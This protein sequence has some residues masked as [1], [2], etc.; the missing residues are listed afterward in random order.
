M[1]KIV[2]FITI[3][4]IFLSFQT[5]KPAANAA[6]PPLIWIIMENA[7]DDIVVTMDSEY[8]Q[9][10]AQIIRV[11]NESY[12][13]FFLHEFY[14]K[15]FEF[16]DYR[17]IQVSLTFSFNQE[18]FS[19]P[20]NLDLGKYNDVYTLN[21][22]SQTLVEGKSLFRD[23][24]Y[25]GLRVSLTLLVEGLIFFLLGFRHRRTWIIFIL[26]NLLTQGTLNVLLISNVPYSAYAILGLV[27]YES[28]IMLVELIGF[29]ITVKEHSKGRVLL[30]VFVANLCSLFIGGYLIMNFPL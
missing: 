17:K 12:A 18:T 8:G 9:M 28:V 14:L 16:D 13:R 3:F 26:I 11:G 24:K 23:L 20:F 5:I 22:Q 21:L 10:E 6:E 7:P 1:R 25:A 30:T 27:M 4:L 29:T 15:G 2:L 19:L